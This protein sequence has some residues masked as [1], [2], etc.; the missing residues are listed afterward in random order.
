[1]KLKKYRKNTKKYKK[2]T[3]KY[4]KNTKKYNRFSKKST[5]GMYSDDSSDDETMQLA[6]WLSLQETKKVP[7]TSRI[8]S[9]A[10]DDSDDSDAE[11]TRLAKR[12]SLEERGNRSLPGPSSDRGVTHLIERLSLEERG[13]PSDESPYVNDSSDDELNIALE[14]SRRTAQEEEKRRREELDSQVA[15]SMEIEEQ[16]QQ[17][18]EEQEQADLNIALQRSLTVD[19]DWLRRDLTLNQYWDITNWVKNIT[20][21]TR[22][23]MGSSA[24]PVKDLVPT[25]CHTGLHLGNDL[26]PSCQ[27][28]WSGKYGLTPQGRSS[29]N[30]C[31][32]CMFTGLGY[33]LEHMS[34][35]VPGM[36]NWELLRTTY[37]LPN[38]IPYMFIDEALTASVYTKRALMKYIS[39]G[40][41]GRR[42]LNQTGQTLEGTPIHERLFV[43]PR[44]FPEE[45]SNFG[46][47]DKLVNIIELIANA[48]MPNET[49]MGITLH[50]GEPVKN[51]FIT[52][53]KETIG[54]YTNLYRDNSGSIKVYDI[55]FEAYKIMGDETLSDLSKYIFQLLSAQKDRKLISIGIIVT[56]VVAN[57][58]NN[59]I[60]AHAPPKLVRWSSL[61]GNNKQAS[62][63]RGGKMT[64][65]KKAK[66]KK[67]KKYKYLKMRPYNSRKYV[68]KTRKN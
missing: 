30:D 40:P 8:D 61:P 68:K 45:W 57:W 9:D 15:Q 52:N 42:T 56:P 23:W 49:M 4:R 41:A 54:H 44:M 48:V 11:V 62:F 34:N 6:K 25:K 36:S 3:K 51:G 20:V 32:A 47:Q 66:K 1:M 14:N 46:Q 60:V 39:R 28:Q 55:Q 13:G 2:N 67:S 43:F 33:Q 50:F 31:G 7:T 21:P 16:E 58:F 53:I 63:S 12:L 38:G 24:Q 18:Q 26:V 64:K 27:K 19:Q 37:G 5:G 29:I 22:I 17:Q 10:S 59:Q 65:K 35:V